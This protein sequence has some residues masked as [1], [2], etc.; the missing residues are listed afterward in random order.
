[1]KGGPVDTALRLQLP[2]PGDLQI[3]PAG[4]FLRAIALLIDHVVMAFAFFILSILVV[5]SYGALP[6]ETARGFILFLYLLLLFVLYNGY[7]FVAEWLMKG[8]TPGKMVCGLRVVKLDGSQADVRSLLIRNLLRPGDMFPY[9]TGAWVLYV[10]TYLLAA[11]VSLVIP[12]FRRLGDLAAGTTVAYER[13]PLLHLRRKISAPRSSAT[14]I[15]ALRHRVDPALYEAVGRFL[16]RRH[17]LSAARR[18]EIASEVY[19]DLKKIFAWTGP[20]PGPE[21]L[22]EQ[23]HLWRIQE[24]PGS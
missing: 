20:D 14:R 18:Q 23:I 12:N 15:Y 3:I 21:E 2:W 9:L 22:I 11:L 10:P 1:M 24:R 19:E 8:Q 13:L 6:V 17:T 7:F 5:V 4:P 16:A